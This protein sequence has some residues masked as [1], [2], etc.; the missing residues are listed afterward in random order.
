VQVVLRANDSDSDSDSAYNMYF[1]NSYAPA[2]YRVA[3]NE[4]GYAA[5]ADAVYLSLLQA[6]P[7]QLDPEILRSIPSWAKNSPGP[8]AAIAAWLLDQNTAIH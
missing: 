5:A 6:C 3:L 4:T 7:C 8:R 2:L 1:D